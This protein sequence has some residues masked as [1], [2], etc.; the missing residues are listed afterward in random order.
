MVFIGRKSFAKPD[1]KH[2]KLYL[3][4]IPNTDFNSLGSSVL[5]KNPLPFTDL[6]SPSKAAIDIL[7]QTALAEPFQTAFGQMMPP[8]VAADPEEAGRV[9]APAQGQSTSSAEK[10]PLVQS[11]LYL[12]DDHLNL[13]SPKSLQE[14]QGL[15]HPSC[16]NRP[17]RG[18]PGWD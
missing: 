15:L 5:A 6:Y 4:V 2:G 3:P 8:G 9:I 17:W 12:G 7:V 14:L 1:R 11:T 13:L 18:L 16:A 10:R